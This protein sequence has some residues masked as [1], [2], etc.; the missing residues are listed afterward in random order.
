MRGGACGWLASGSQR[1]SR[2][3]GPSGIVCR[4]STCLPGRLGRRRR[5]RCCLRRWSRCRLGRLGALGEGVAH[6]L[7]PAL[8]VETQ[9]SPG[10][11]Q[12]TV[13]APM[14]GVP[15]VGVPAMRETKKTQ[16]QGDPSVTTATLSAGLHTQM[17]E[18]VSAACVTKDTQRSHTENPC[19]SKAARKMRKWEKNQ[20]ERG[21]QGGILPRVGSG[22]DERRDSPLQRL[23]RWSPRH[24]Q[25]TRRRTRS[26]G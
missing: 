10:Q 16:L 4:S 24:Q 23:C 13:F 26:H 2:R 21:A 22:I 3:R 1:S 18:H 8:R 7:G 5:R 6:V 17:H 14:M 20:A 9:L 25:Q 19:L 12:R 11:V 15:L